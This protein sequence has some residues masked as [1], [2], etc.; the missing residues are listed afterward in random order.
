MSRRNNRKGEVMW[1]HPVLTD[2]SR[3]APASTHHRCLGVPPS[4]SMAILQAFR[5]LQ[6]RYIE[7]WL[8]TRNTRKCACKAVCGETLRMVLV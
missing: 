6:K 4:A 3:G 8:R 2:F 7:V 1:L 5:H